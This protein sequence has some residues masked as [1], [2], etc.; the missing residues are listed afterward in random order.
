MIRRPPRSTLFPYTTLF[1]SLA[2]F[3][4]VVESVTRGPLTVVTCVAVLFV[5]LGST[6]LAVT[7]A[8]LVIVPA[9]VGLTTIVI[10]ARAALAS[11]PRLHTTMLVPVQLP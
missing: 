2:K 7:L 9:E 6:S 11:V 5:G 1:R 3:R 10:V 8:V 4:F